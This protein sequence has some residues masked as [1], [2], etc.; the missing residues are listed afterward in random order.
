MDTNYNMLHH[1]THT[2][3]LLKP[4]TSKCI[5]I[6]RAEVVMD[7]TKNV[8]TTHTSVGKF[9]IALLLSNWEI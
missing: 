9:V 4:P 8:N 5:L 6:I 3:I 7:L 2:H 1:Y